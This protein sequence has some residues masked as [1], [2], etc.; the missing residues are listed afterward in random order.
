MWYF[1]TLT[2]ISAWFFSTV[3]VDFVAIPSVFRILDDPA[4]A[5]LI[6]IKVFSTFNI[7]EV[8]I[9]ITGLVGA[10]FLRHKGLLVLSILTISIAFLYYFYLT[11]SIIS[12]S[13]VIR[14]FNEL[15]SQVV[16]EKTREMAFFHELYVKMDSIKLL[17]LLCSLILLGM[18]RARKL[19]I[20]EGKV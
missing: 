13:E 12:A 10:Y 7:L 16:E 8:I 3:V 20:N 19:A 18:P 17:L 5:G 14:S 4:T 15:N 9:A 6:G 11:P 2:S 1:L